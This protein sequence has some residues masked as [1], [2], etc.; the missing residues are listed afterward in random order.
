VLIGTA[1]GVLL[2]TRLL[3]AQGLAPEV[4]AWAPR[5]VVPALVILDLWGFAAGYNATAPAAWIYPETP[6]IRFLRARQAAFPGARIMPVNRDWSLVRHPYA[7]LPPNAALALGLED[8]QGYDSLFIG[9]YK[10]LANAANSGDSSPAENGNMLFFRDPTSSLLPLLGV[11]SVITREP[12]PGASPL[13]A[14]EGVHVYD[15]ESALPRAFLVERAETAPTEEA[16]LEALQRLA[17]RGAGALRERIILPAGVEPPHSSGATATASLPDPDWR[18]VGPN[19]YEVRAR[20]SRPSWLLLTES[21]APG[22]RAAVVGE[23]GDT[24]DVPVARGD[25]GFLAARLPAG[26]WTVR[27]RYEPESLRRGLFLAGLAWLA[28]AAGAG[29]RW[30]GR[31]RRLSG[32]RSQPL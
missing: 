15:I 5:L 24:R 19:G 21:W 26:E 6:V 8:V 7:V 20:P 13:A 2:V 1:A 27:L 25:F 14:A 17:D 30:S 18:R 23:G 32:E 11:R 16:E 29:A 3:A 4:A 22:W 31:R 10:G 9:R 12:L 28:L